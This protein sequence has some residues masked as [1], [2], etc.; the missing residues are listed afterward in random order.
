MK[1]LWISIVKFPP[2]A[3]FL[4]E[5]VPA[6]GGWMYPSALALLQENP[7]LEL[8]VVIPIDTKKFSVQ[9]I[10]GITYFLVPCEGLAKVTKEMVNNCQ[11]IVEQFDPKLIHLHGTEFSLALAMLRAGFNGPV[12][13][14][15]QGLAGA[16]TRYSNGGLSFKD[17]LR[18]ISL[19][20]IL[21]L[22]TQ[23][24]TEKSF[25]SRGILESELIRNLTDVI[26]R[27]SWDKAHCKAINSKINYHFCNET[28]RESFYNAEWQLDN[29]D[30]QSI[31]V[32]NS[33]SALK[34]AHQVIKALPI[35]LKQYPETLIS[36]VGP[37]VFDSRWKN[38][39]RFTGYHLY[40][41]RLIKRLN[42]KD[43]VKF[44]G[45]LTEVEMRDA[46]LS[47]NL[48]VLPSAIE[49]SPNSLC[50]AQI[51]GV[52]SIASYVGGIPDLVKHESTGFL[53]RYEEYEMLAQL[54]IDLFEIKEYSSLSYNTKNI[55]KKRHN[56][57][58]NAKTLLEIYRNIIKR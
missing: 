26:G 38:K 3:K 43:N 32:S 21:R 2:V 35:I 12:V 53:Y 15:I 23:F 57:S 1:I 47:C 52:P 56:R 19:R 7:D 48:Y 8:G 58:T 17:R 13:A 34:G 42:L 18:N 45:T 5:T 50:E 4:G 39:I 36:F 28:L 9:K 27:T 16:Y 46:F 41:R 11:L 29:C 55:A 37:N 6:W 33:S 24:Q 54:V 30:K 25:N 31:F 44:L 14:S 20:D 22:D 10:D 49:N 40:L 51:L